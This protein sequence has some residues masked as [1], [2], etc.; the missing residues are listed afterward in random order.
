MRIRISD[1]ITPSQIT[2]CVQKVGKYIFVEPE[3]VYLLLTRIKV[4]GLEEVRTVYIYK[5][6][7]SKEP[8]ATDDY[9]CYRGYMSIYLPL[10][11]Y[12]PLSGASSGRKK[13]EKVKERKVL[14]HLT[15]FPLN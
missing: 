11:I 1:F 6:S 15:F 3:C 10:S 9:Q 5:L 12:N 13:L 14:L 8:G 2:F 7:P 4:V